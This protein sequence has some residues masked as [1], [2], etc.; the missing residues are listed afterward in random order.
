MFGG[1]LGITEL[2]IILAI[3]LI[4]FGGRRIPEV[5]RGM[6]EGIRSFKD[7]MSGT[8]KPSGDKPAG[9][10]PAEDKK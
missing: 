5:M 10:K 3:V 7:G 1:K 6:G 4:F 8:D 2:L 9:D